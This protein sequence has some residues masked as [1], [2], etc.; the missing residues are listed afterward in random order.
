MAGPSDCSLI[1]LQHHFGRFDD[2]GDLVAFLEAKLLRAA[3]SDHAFN[4][5]LPDEHAIATKGRQRWNL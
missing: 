3:A 2:H 5:D 1:F 4:L